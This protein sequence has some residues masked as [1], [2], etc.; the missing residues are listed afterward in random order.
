MYTSVATVTFE[1]FG[2]T[3]PFG[4]TNPSNEVST[5]LL[6]YGNKDFPDE[7][8][9]NI[10]E[11]TL[12]FIHETTGDSDTVVVL[13]KLRKKQY[14]IIQYSPLASNVCIPVKYRGQTSWFD[15]GP[16]PSNSENSESQLQQQIASLAYPNE[17][18][19][20]QRA[21]EKRNSS[22]QG[23]VAARAVR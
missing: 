19:S 1:P 3:R 12:Q 23:L 9:R 10:L 16:P 4:L 7:I 2:L 13:S 22:S 17:L 8:N 20:Q 18:P 11:L 6:M 15:L 21:L 14:I 5:Q